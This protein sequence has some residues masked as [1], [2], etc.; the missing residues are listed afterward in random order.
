MSG[1]NPNTHSGL[2]SGDDHEMTESLS[3]SLSLI[4]TGDRLLGFLSGMCCLGAA[5][6]VW[7][8]I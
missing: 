3:L 2:V 7:H 6:A 5:L 4:R 8:F 1:I